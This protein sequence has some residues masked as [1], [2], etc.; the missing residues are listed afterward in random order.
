[1]SPHAEV[2]SENGGL[3]GKQVVRR[4]LRFAGNVQPDFLESG[5]IDGGKN[6]RAVQLSSAELRKRLERA[7]GG[8]I[9]GGTDGKGNQRF[10]CIKAG[11]MIPEKL[12][13]QATDRIDT[14]SEFRSAAEEEPRRGVVFPVTS[15]PFGSSMQTAGFP[16]CSEARSAGATTRRKSIVIPAWAIIISHL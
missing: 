6:D 16:V 4:K 8:V 3:Q 1:M 10:V 15:F 11:I 2:L 12:G 7:F 14:F 13:F 9:L 5:G